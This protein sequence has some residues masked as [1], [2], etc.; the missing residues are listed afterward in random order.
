MSRLLHT[1][2]IVSLLAVIGFRVYGYFASTASEV[3]SARESLE[4]NDVSQWRDAAGRAFATEDWN[5]AVEACEKIVA[6]EPGGVQAWVRLAYAHHQLGHYDQ[7]IAAFLRVC[8]WEGRPRQWALFHL[9]AAYA[10]KHEKQPEL[11]CKPIALV[12]LREAVEAGFRQSSDADEPPVAQNPDFS[13]IA[14]DPEFQR[15]AELTKPISQRNVYRQLDFIVGRWF[16]D[17]PDGQPIGSAEFAGASGEY[18]LVGKCAD[19]KR[20]TNS[21]VL[22][23]CDPATSQWQQVWV[24]DHGSVT[25]LTGQ[26]SYGG[27]LIFEG[28][29]TTADGRSFTSRLVFDQAT[30]GTIHVSLMS[31]SDG[32]DRW[33]DVL[34]ANL[35]ADTGPDPPASEGTGEPS[36]SR[37]FP[38]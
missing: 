3:R 9:A 26:P 21:I 14:D 28:E 19:N 27:T 31:S 22:A 10:R 36:A 6:V 34:D 18:A 23:Y 2:L 37:R 1:V 38:R 15:L 8:D 17:S 30:D 24:D 25:R 20:A 7:A 35:R 11:D 29:M 13:S 12:F 33:T 32:G 4:T 5:L 16:L